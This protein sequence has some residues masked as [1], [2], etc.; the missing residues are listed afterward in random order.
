M[1]AEFPVVPPV[2]DGTT[3]S[4]KAMLLDCV[5]HDRG[6]G[7]VPL[8]ERGLRV[9]RSDLLSDAG[10]VRASQIERNEPGAFE[11]G[12]GLSRMSHKAGKILGQGYRVGCYEA[13]K[14]I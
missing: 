7:G 3:F 8:A 13:K 4:L 11:L 10:R 5:G 1:Q 9:P 2:L 12:K 14:D 6:P